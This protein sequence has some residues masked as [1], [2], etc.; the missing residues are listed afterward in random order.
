LGVDK[1]EVARFDVEALAGASKVYEKRTRIA[2]GEHRVAASFLNDYYKPDDPDPA[3]RDRNLAVE[4]V[5]VVGPVDDPIPSAF[6]ARELDP[7][8]HRTPR[9]VVGR[10]A[11]RAWRRPPSAA[12]V[13]K[14]LALAPKDATPAEQVRAA[15]QGILISPRFLFLFEAD[16][17]YA[18]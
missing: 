1:K 16:D 8:L 4:W 5:E 10:L 3:N 13:D 2:A 11:A 6:Q 9:Q 15:I 12:D 18:L 14:L 17:D 7:A